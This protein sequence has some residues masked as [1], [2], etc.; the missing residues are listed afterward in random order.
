MYI[1]L[2]KKMN[3]LETQLVQREYDGRWE[4]IAKIMDYDNAYKYSNESGTTMTLIPEKWI[5]LKVYD[6]I[7]EIVDDF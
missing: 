1:W 3:I 7:M 2:Q 5:T 4:Y 6:F